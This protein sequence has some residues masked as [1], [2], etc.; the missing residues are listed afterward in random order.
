MPSHDLGQVRTSMHA[1]SEGDD[2]PKSKSTYMSS[3]AP[4]RAMTLKFKASDERAM[5]FWITLAA[6]CRRLNNLRKFRSSLHFIRFDRQFA[7]DNHTND[8]CPLLMS[9]SSCKHATGPAGP[10][11]AV[12]GGCAHLQQRAGTARTVRDGEW[13]PA[14]QLVKSPCKQ[15][16]EVPHALTYEQRVSLPAINTETYS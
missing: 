16:G 11:P 9:P 4:P 2:L 14:I 15:N 12:C 3:S 5:N 6:S 7:K 10:R 1:R 13:L 8:L